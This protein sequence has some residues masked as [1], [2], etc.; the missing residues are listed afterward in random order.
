[1]VVAD[2]ESTLKKFVLISHE[3]IEPEDNVIGSIETKRET[4][5]VGCLKRARSL[6]VR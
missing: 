3:N 4:G 2:G 1:M 5:G 6:W